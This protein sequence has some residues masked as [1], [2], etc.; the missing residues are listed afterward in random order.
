MCRQIGLPES[1]LLE[2]KGREDIACG[3]WTVRGIPSLHS[4]VICGRVPFPGDIASPPN[5]P[6][7]VYELKHGLVL[8]WLIDTG[9]LR[10]MHIDSADY[11][12]EEIA[13]H[14]V[15]VLCLCAVGR[16]YKPNYVKEVVSL[17]KPRWV[18]PCHWDTMMTPIDASPS[19]IPGV[20]LPG[21]MREIRNENVEP[22]LIPLLGK[23]TFGGQDEH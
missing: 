15:D 3:K 17:V 18:V 5:W 23:I 2:A 9:E 11:I 7:R 22:L 14:Q 8:N 13:E 16:R 21:F 12:A 10:V 20:D 4:K 6:P 19:M 1:Q